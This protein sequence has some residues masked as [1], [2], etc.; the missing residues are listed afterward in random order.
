MYM[1]LELDFEPMRF[2]SGRGYWEEYSIKLTRCTVTQ[3]MALEKKSDLHV[4]YHIFIA[5]FSSFLVSF[6]MILL[7]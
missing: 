1:Y 6:C 3:L 5:S 7:V 4:S 2:Y